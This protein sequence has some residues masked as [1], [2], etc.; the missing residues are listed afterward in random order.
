MADPK[1]AAILAKDFVD[2]KIDTDRNTGGGEMHRKYNTMI[3][4]PTGGGIPWFA[5]VNADGKAIIDSNGP[6]GNTGFPSADEEVA[7]FVTMLKAAKKNMTGA[8][9][10]ALESSLK[11]AKVE[12]H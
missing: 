6:K 9:I 5:F 7:H 10:S 2:C 1:V 12:G 4:K 8:D 11:A 3:D